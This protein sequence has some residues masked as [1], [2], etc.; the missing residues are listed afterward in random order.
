MKTLVNCTPT[1]FFVQTGRIKK[2]VEKW[3]TV[4]DIINI[5]SRKPEY[6]EAAKG[7]TADERKSVIQRNAKR[8]QD[9]AFKNAS[10][11]LDAL[12]VEHPEETLEM[13]SLCC[14]IEPDDKDNHSVKE[15][16]R[17]ANEIINDDDV[18]DFFTSLAL[19]VQKRSST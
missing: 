11:V 17:A 16:L 13:L 10:D 5:R 15:Y 19:L 14:F 7:L 3:L 9:Q 12:L 1:E 8:E 4:T 18:R 6:E 2:S